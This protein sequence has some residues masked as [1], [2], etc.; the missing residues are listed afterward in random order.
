MY[1]C[2]LTFTNIF[3]HPRWRP[4][5]CTC[6]H[7]SSCLPWVFCGPSSPPRPLWLSLSFSFYSYLSGATCYLSSL[8]NGNWPRYVTVVVV[9]V[10]AATAAAVVVVGII[11]NKYTVYFI[12]L[13]SQIGRKPYSTGV[14]RYPCSLRG[15]PSIVL[16]QQF[17][18]GS[19]H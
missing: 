17:P 16:I 19:E 1:T 15:L 18:C 10:A 8:P 4:G 11:K 14:C 6:S 7:C 12:C 2:N 13:R 9:V 5:G 3:P